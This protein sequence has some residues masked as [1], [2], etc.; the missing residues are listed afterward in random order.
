MG[1]YNTAL[2]RGY[3][4]KEALTIAGVSYVSTALPMIGVL[5]YDICSNSSATQK[6]TAAGIGAIASIFGYIYGSHYT[7]S[8]VDKLRTTNSS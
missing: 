8:L 2:S 7:K 6:G 3:T 4:K 5:I 1:L